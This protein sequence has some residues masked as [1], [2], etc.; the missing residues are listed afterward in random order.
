METTF[1]GSGK[2]VNGHE[3]KDVKWNSIPGKYLGMVFDHSYMGGKWRILTWTK[4]GK[5][6]KGF[7]HF[8]LIN[9]SKI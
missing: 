9:P 4:V 2:T 3:V 6:P 8:N 5:A 7:E 1:N